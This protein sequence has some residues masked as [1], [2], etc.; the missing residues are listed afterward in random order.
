MT[1]IAPSKALHHPLAGIADVLR[2]EFCTLRSVRSTFWTLIFALVSNVVLAALVAIF[3]PS[4]LSAQEKATLDSVRVSLAGLHLSQIAFG[5]LGALVITSEYGTGVIRATLAA[6]PRRRLLLAA[7]TLVFAVTSLIIGTL[8][9]LAAYVV[10]Q[11]FLSDPSLR[12]SISDPGV[13]RAVTGGGLY[14]TVLGLLGLGLGAILRSS[15]GAIAALFGL[16][17]GP[18]ILAGILPQSWQNTITPYLP[19]NSGDAICSLHHDAGSLEAWTGFG[20]FCLY[21]AIALG[22]GFLLITHCDA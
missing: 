7:K 6:V 14:L 8:A 19:M 10:F 4:H 5:A 3:L 17:F 20:V 12:T 1:V 9:C 16:L 18:T 21:A 22:G 11:A 15:A 13:L 2:S